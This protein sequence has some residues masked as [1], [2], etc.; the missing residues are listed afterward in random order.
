M[1]NL[2]LCYWLKKA[3][4]TTKMYLNL[5]KKLVICYFWSTAVY[6][7]ETWAL[8]KVDQKY[9]KSSE[10][11]SWTKLEKISWTDHMRND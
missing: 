9:L 10:T 5:R 7:A 2:L 1:R 8:Q 4:Y 6:G 11:V 3:L